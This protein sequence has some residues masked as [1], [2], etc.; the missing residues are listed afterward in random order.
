MAKTSWGFGEYNTTQ[1]SLPNQDL[2][3]KSKSTNVLKLLLT[4]IC[5]NPILLLMKTKKYFYF[6][7]LCVISQLVHMIMPGKKTHVFYICTGK[8]PNNLLK[9]TF[10]VNG[11][12]YCLIVFSVICHLFVYSHFLVKKI[13]EKQSPQTVLFIIKLILLI[14]LLVKTKQ[15][16]YIYSLHLVPLIMLKSGPL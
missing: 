8:L 12:F 3:K 7:G 6:I 2:G 11:S 14:F 10:K 15:F 16:F 1:S 13:K 9:S 4:S 5:P